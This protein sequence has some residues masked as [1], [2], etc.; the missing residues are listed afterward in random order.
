MITHTLSIEHAQFEQVGL[1]PRF[2]GEKFD[3]LLNELVPKPDPDALN[4]TV[5]IAPTPELL[6]FSRWRAMLKVIHPYNW[7]TGVAMGEY[8]E[9]TWT[10]NIFVDVDDV[11]NNNER[12]LHETSHWADHATGVVG[13]KEDQ[14]DTRAKRVAIAMGAQALSWG[15]GA[16]VYAATH[17]SA[18]GI[19][20]ACVATTFATPVA[21]SMIRS[22][23]YLSDP[24]EE[25][26]RGFAADPDILHRYG[27]ILTV[28][29]NFHPWHWAAQKMK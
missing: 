13:L 16:G 18:A 29:G 12:V 6:L 20:T 11:T 24:T 26:A 15:A 8:N 28:E 21:F 9:K 22:R 1:T 7:N 4:P 19:L 5:R 27:D 3:Q 2:N 14:P 17:N 23:Y 25:A 10:L